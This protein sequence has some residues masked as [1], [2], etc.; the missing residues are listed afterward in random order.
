MVNHHLRYLHLPLSSGRHTFK[1]TLPVRITATYS[2]HHREA[3]PPSPRLLVRLQSLPLGRPKRLFWA[4][5]IAEKKQQQTRQVY[6][7]FP[8]GYGRVHFLDPS[9]PLWEAKYRIFLEVEVS[10]SQV[11]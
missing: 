7:E 10:V 8:R 9:W 6:H 2:R 11:F 3:H 1:Q 4:T 5:E